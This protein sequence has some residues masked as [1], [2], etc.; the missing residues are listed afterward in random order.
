MEDHL[1]YEKHAKSVVENNRNVKTTKRIK[2][3][4][5]DFDLETPM[6]MMAHLNRN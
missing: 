5:G 1:G 3:E 4:D 2:T 6:T